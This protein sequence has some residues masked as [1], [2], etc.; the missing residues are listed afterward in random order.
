MATATKKTTTTK[1]KVVQPKAPIAPATIELYDYGGK[2]LLAS[3]TVVPKNNERN[4]I[5][6]VGRFIYQNKLN[7][8]HLLEKW[9]K[10]N[11][12]IRIIKTTGNSK[13]SG[14]WF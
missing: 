6:C 2:Q 3:Q 12:I 13:T 14:D 10:K 7:T 8:N 11:R 1:K 4:F 9:D 5:D